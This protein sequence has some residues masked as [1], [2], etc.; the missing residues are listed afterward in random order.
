[1]RM[2]YSEQL[3]Q[4]LSQLRQRAGLSQRKVSEHFE[5]STPQFVS[6]YERGVTPPPGLN[7]Y[8]LKELYE[9]DDKTFESLRQMWMESQWQ[10]ALEKPRRE[11]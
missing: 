5:W 9:I 8:Q 7:L 6:N 11:R 2:S 10:K 1:M 3:G 4:K